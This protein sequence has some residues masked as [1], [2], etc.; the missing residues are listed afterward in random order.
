M[1]TIRWTIQAVN[2][3]EAIRRFI[4]NDSPAYADLVVVR[5]LACVERLATFPQSGRTVPEVS[6]SDIREVI[7]RP[8]RVVYRLREQAVEVLTVFRASR[9]FP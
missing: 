3:I 4:G 9:Q 5:L 7:E 2:D 6:D 8:Y 1:T